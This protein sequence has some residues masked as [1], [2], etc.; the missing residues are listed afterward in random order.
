MDSIDLRSHSLEQKGRLPDTAVRFRHFLSSHLGAWKGLLVILYVLSAT[1]A[2]RAQDSASVVGTIVDA[3]SSA[4][5]GA[6]LTARNTETG[7]TRKTETDVAGH[8]E[9]PLLNVGTYEVQV[10]RAG[11][12]PRNVSGIV[13]VLGQRAVVDLTLEVGDIQETV[14]VTEQASGVDVTT[15][16]VW[17]L[18]ENVR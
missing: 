10:E 15:S 16:D 4:V 13:L 11:F 14:Q 7:L 1:T 18:S 6:Q 17:V 12:K 9:F 8:Y 2:V 3:T 5:A